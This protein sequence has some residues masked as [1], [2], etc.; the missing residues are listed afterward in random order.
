ML[1][2]HKIA[3]AALDVFEKEPLPAS[4]LLTELDNVL[5]TPHSAMASIDGFK[6]V[7]SHCVRNI[8]DY[9]ADRNFKGLVNPDYRKYKEKRHE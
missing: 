5:L 4:S 8:L 6:S 1:R 7:L 3:G 2:E 9:E